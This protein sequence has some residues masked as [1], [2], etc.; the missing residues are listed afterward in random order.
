MEHLQQSF[1]VQLLGNFKFDE[2]LND[3]IFFYNC[4]FDP[5]NPS[6]FLELSSC[7]ASLELNFSSLGRKA[8]HQKMPCSAKEKISLTPMPYSADENMGSHSS[9]MKRTSHVKFPLW[10]YY[11]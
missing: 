4:Y 6:L 8:M 3:A 5:S 11:G 9:V 2:F 7:V 1:A 10:V